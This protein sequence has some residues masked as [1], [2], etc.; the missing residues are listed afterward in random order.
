M[1]D[2][3]SPAALE[4]S[5]PEFLKRDAAKEGQRKEAFPQ[6]EADVNGGDQRK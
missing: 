2:Q 6:S 1:N 4:Q 5:V 3:V